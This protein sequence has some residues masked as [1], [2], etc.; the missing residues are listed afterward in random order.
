[1]LAH[2][3]FVI[4]DIRVEG[5]QRISAGTVF[6]Y[7][8]VSVGSRLR[9][10]DY[11]QLIRTLFQTGFFTDVGL[12]QDGDVLVVTV[13][14]RPAIAE[15]N[16]SGNKDIST[17]DLQKALTGV[18]LAEGRVFDRSLLDKV[19][20][21]L[22]RQYYARGKYAVR[23]DTQ[24]R[25]LERNRV[26]VSL[27]ISEGVAA[28][29]RQI[30]IV[31]NQDFSN[32]D[33]M[34]Q[35]QLAPTNWWSILT[36][37]DQYS[38][39]KLAADLENLR[40]FYL[41]RGYLTFAIEST[42]VSI[43]P[44]KKDIYVT[45]NISEGEPYTVKDTQLAGELIVPEDELKSLITIEPGQVFSRS[46]MNE[47]T[48]RMNE[49]LGDEGYAF[50]N[51]NTVPQMDEDTKQVSLTFVLDPGKRVYVRRINFTGNTKTY[52][53]VLRREM[54]QMEAAWFSTQDVNRS[55]TRLERLGY[56]ESVNV[57]TPAVPGSTDQ[58][59]INYTVTE[60]PSGNLVFGLGYGQESGPL[61][62][63]SIN[64][65]NF[66]GTGNQ[67]SFAFNNSDTNTVY[68]FAYNN[69][70]YT[71]DGISRGFR[72][73]YRETDA[74][75]SNIADYLTDGY[76]A[77]MRFGIPVNEFDSVRLGVGFEGLEIKTTDETPTEIE[78]FLAEQ[79]DTF[80]NF[81]LDLGWSNDSRNRAIFADRGSLNRLTAEIT[82]PGSDAEYYKVAF[83]HETFLPLTQSL[84]LS[85]GGEVGYGDGYGDFD[86]LPFFEN[87]FA[88]GLST[89]R[90]FKANTL[91]PRYASTDE[92]SGGSV[93]LIGNAA[94][95]FPVPFADLGESMRLSTFL[96]V[97]NVF[98][99]TDE[100]DA[101]DLRYS[102]GLSVLWLT[103][104]G[105]LALSA[106]APLNE[107]EGDDTETL[108]FSFG[109]PF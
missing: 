54:R 96:D 102:V 48:R 7:L 58:V 89:V 59:D 60:L 10:E 90:G 79:G 105:P 69:P 73:Y 108:Q 57:E 74:G 49:R 23:L 2:G 8:P 70:Y 19:E 32:D 94:V 22:L 11:P 85:L 12:S 43:T 17:E 14:E 16:I 28:R 76:G 47:T 100:F 93:K 21:E 35:F 37:G 55:K 56:L 107:Q 109:V 34:D 52:D 15:I 51:V 92:A 67:V 38:K 26:D 65:K 33:L 81:K 30:N 24:V 68:S 64:Q 77:E 86:S 40:S 80:N 88:G 20:Q 13:T 5:L 9:D 98:D 44:D 75:E 25:S 42:Q 53:E 101:G 97:G 78:S 4:S 41:D 71:I 104:V 50:A 29:I 87:Y 99:G 103:P 6:N 84:V 3:D 66:M 72:V 39:Q 1:M 31:G 91:G 61:F 46:A 83:K 36:R 27:D 63:A 18:G 106:A 45:I 62:N 95:I 82:L